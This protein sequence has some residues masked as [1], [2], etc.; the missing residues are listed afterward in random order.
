MENS[1]RRTS[2]SYKVT[3]VAIFALY[4]I[5]LTKMLTTKC[6]PLTN[7]FLVYFIFLNLIS[8]YKSS[9]HDPGALQRS[10][11]PSFCTQPI[12]L[13]SKIE[14]ISNLEDNI[15]NELEQ[16]NE[17]C[18]DEISLSEFH[19]SS[20]LE[21]TDKPKL[22]SG[23]IEAIQ[24]IQNTQENTRLIVC[25]Q[26]NI[27]YSQKYCN[28]CN[29]YRPMKTSHCSDCGYCI[30]ERCHHCIWLD[31]CIGRN[32]YRDYLMFIFSLTVLSYLSMFSLKSICE[33]FSL[34]RYIY[35]P[36]LGFLYIFTFLIFMFTIFNFVLAIFNITPKEFKRLPFRE[37]PSVSFKGLAFRLFR[38]RPPIS[39]I[40]NQ[41]QNQ[42]I[43]Q[44]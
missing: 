4:S 29:L 20:S 16:N 33:E 9:M 44:A 36:S 37:F 22:N 3:L 39:L 10:E 24:I 32:N 5:S 19:D 23:L 2:V 8:L 6:K 38:D 7:I 18:M 27:V 30:L 15:D 21:K 34:S 25:N 43:M 17:E 41:V 12:V 14:S 28:V 35:L 40:Q 31:N 11:N 1:K 42:Y 26:E 13:L